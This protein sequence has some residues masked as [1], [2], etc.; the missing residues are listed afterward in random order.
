MLERIVTLA[1]KRGKGIKMCAFIVITKTTLVASPENI[2]LY[3][4]FRN[5]QVHEL[6][7]FM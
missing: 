3:G 6:Q 4:M 2:F 7:N 5:V 1:D